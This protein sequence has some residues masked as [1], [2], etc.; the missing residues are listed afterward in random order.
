MVDHNLAMQKLGMLQGDGAIYLR[1]LNDYPDNWYFE[2][3]CFEC[4]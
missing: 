3:L 4:Q 2:K 1:L